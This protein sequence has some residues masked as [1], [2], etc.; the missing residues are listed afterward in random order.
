MQRLVDRL[1]GLSEDVVVFFDGAAFGVRSA[2]N[3]EVRFASR[4]GRDAA[5]DDIAAFVAAHD[6]P[7]S[8]R[9]VTSDSE[10]AARVEAHGAEVEPAGGFARRL[11]EGG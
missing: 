6:D 5:D 11:E 3:V 7:S 9:V 8:L 2:G 1:G 4:R 10:L